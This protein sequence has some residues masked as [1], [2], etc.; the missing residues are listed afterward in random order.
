[1]RATN[2]EISI[3]SDLT[4]E[5][6]RAKSVESELTTNL[7]NEVSRATTQENIIDNKF[8]ALIDG[9]TIRLNTLADSDDTTLDQLSEIVSYI[10]NNKN[11]IDNITTGKVNVTDIIDNL[12]STDI[13]KPLSANQG[14]I[15]KDLIDTLTK[16]NVGLSNVDNKSSE[17]IRNELTYENV[18]QALGYNPL[19]QS[20]IGE[21]RFEV[22][23]NYDLILIA[24][25]GYDPPLELGNDGNLYYCFS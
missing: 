15:L 8:S 16:D 5:I 17:D 6:S 9:L 13:N 3:I 19:G 20:G 1:M 22:D 11:L 12:I 18:V 4:N 21:M 25:D 10:K 23:E 14:K 24:P 2:K 7:S